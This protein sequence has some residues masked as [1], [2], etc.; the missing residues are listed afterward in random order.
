M[1]VFTLNVLI[2]KNAMEKNNATS[3]V[4][5]DSTFNCTFLEY[6]NPFGQ[7]QQLSFFFPL[8]VD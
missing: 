2:F 1:I 5:S 8:I 3:D 4:T 6:S 7:K